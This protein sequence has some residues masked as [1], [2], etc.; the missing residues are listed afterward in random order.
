MTR[1]ELRAE[2]QR[3]CSSPRIEDSYDLLNIYADYFLK[4]IKN[5][6]N[7]PVKDIAEHQAHIVNQMMLTKILHI[8]QIITGVS[9]KS[10]DGTSLNEIIDP[11]VLATL[12]RNVYE[13]VCMFNLIYRHSKT[14]DEKLILYNLW[15]IAGLKYRQKFESIISTPENSQVLIEEQQLIKENVSVIEQ[16]KLYTGL[17]E[18]NKEKIQNKIK[19]KD[20]KIRFE[21]NNVVFLNWQELSD[22]TGIKY[23]L[24][25]AVYTYFSLYAHPSNVAVQQF[26][27]MFFEETQ[28]FLGFTS[29]NLKNLCCLLSAFVADFIYLFPKVKVTFESQSLINQLVM[30]GLNKMSRGVEYSINDSYKVLG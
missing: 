14:D 15:V 16:T 24:F 18:K 20:Y 9:F 10:S 22:T 29:Y 3:L 30:N 5:H 27:E 8:K 4:T 7:D 25:D 19:E 21:N 2:F 6:F 13:T 12:I 28:H 17:D 26:G 11:T 23:K 1:D